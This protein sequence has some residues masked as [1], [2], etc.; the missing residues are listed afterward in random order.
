[1]TYHLDSREP[2][3]KHRPS[4]EAQK[5]H[6]EEDEHHGHCGRPAFALL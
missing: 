1:M 6:V 3:V 5:E 4:N 2:R